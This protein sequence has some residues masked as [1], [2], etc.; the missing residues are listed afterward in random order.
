MARVNRIAGSN[1]RHGCQAMRRLMARAKA[2]SGCSGTGLES[3]GPVDMGAGRL[4]GAVYPPVGGIP[5]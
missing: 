5:G 4:P 2:I 3:L 1:S